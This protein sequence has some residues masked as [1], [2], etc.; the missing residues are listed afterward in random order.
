MMASTRTYGLV[1][2]KSAPERARKVIGALIENVKD[3]YNIVHAGNSESIEDV[4]DL[5]RSVQPPPSILCCASMWTPEQQEHIQRTAS[6]V[7]PGIKT[8]AI[9]TGLQKEVDPLGIIDY[10]TE[11]IDTTM[12]SNKRN[13]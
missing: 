11:R 5:L 13:E 6:E 9:P 4:P 3:R 7:I 1:T 8:H 10:L 12:G 2:V